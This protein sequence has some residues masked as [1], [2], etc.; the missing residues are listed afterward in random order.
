MH[1]RAPGD[2]PRAMSGDTAITERLEMLLVLQWL[3]EGRPVDG[4]VLL[5][6]PTAAGELDLP[7]EGD[8]LLAVLTALAEL[9]ESGRASVSWPRGP[10]ADA[11]VVLAQGIRLDAVR[12]F[13]D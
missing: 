3:D 4:D 9:E 10:A 12:L 8:G 6:I 13:G 7:A 11:R 2:Y 1:R 5:S